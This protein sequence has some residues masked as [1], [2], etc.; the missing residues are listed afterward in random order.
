VI[1]AYVDHAHR[2]ESVLFQPVS[3]LFDVEVQHGLTRGAHRLVVGTGYRR[4]SDE[5]RDGFLVGFRPTGRDLNWANAYAQDTVSIGRDV[6]ATLGLKLERNDYTG[7]EYQPNL[8]LSWTPSPERLL[9]GAISRAVRAPARFDRDVIRPLGGVLGGPDFVSEMATVFQLGY[10]TRTAGILNWSVT[11]YLHDWDKLRSG[12]VAPV[13]FENRV[14]GLVFG[15]TTWGSWQVLPR[16][17]VTIGAT[18]LQKDLRVK[19]GSVG[20]APVSIA[21]LG[22][23]PDSQWAVRSSITPARRHEFDA[24]VRRIGALPDP[25]VPAYTAVD[26]RYAWRA[27]PDLELWVT[28]TNLFDASHPEFGALPGRSEFERGVHAGVTWSR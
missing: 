23:D 4:S 6:Q 7:W 8:R 5:V 28:G 20:V 13:V 10:R 12:T 9:W 26:A 15:L 11:T 2:D 14:E 1:Q 3:T 25:A 24:M 19:P 22:N 21:Q 16:W 27:R 18:V 17:R